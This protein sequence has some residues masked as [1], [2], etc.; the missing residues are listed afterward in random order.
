MKINIWKAL[1]SS[2]TVL[3]S[4]GLGLAG[5]VLMGFILI[6][7][8]SL[9][10]KISTR[11]NHEL[12]ENT[13]LPIEIDKINIFRKLSFEGL[14]LID[15]AADTLLH[16]GQLKI[17]VA[18]LPLLGKELV[19][20]SIHINDAKTSVRQKAD[21]EKYNFQFIIDSLA[22]SGKDTTKGHK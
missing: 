6:N 1:K 19:I 21:S 5:L 13:G 12:R 18:L 11:I 10:D 15:P 22:H 16:I 14:L 2:L 7:F 20:N 9:Q 3:I 8:T 17:S 4:I